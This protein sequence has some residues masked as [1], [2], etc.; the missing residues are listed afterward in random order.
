MPRS[1]IARIRASAAVM[2]LCARMVSTSCSSIVSTGFRLVIGSW[3]IMAISL[4]RRPR[5]STSG[6]FV[7]ST[8]SN[9]T[10]PP[11][12]RP[13][14]CGSRRMIAR[15]VTLLP[16][17]DSPTR[18]RVSP[19]SRSNE[20]PFTAWTVPSWVRNRTVRSR[21]ESSIV[22]YR[23]RRGSI[24]SRSPSPRRVNPIARI[25]IATPG[26]R[27][28]YGAFWRNRAESVSISPHSATRG[29]PGPSPRNPRPATSMIA[30]AIASVAWTISG[31]RAFGIRC[32]NRIRAGVAPSARAAVTK[33]ASRNARRLPR[34]SRAKIGAYETPTASMICTWPWPSQATIPIASRIPGTASRTSVMRIRTVSTLPPTPPASAPMVVPKMSPKATATTPTVRLIRAPYRTRLN[35]SRPSRSVPM[36]WARSGPCLLR[37]RFPTAGSYG[38]MIGASTA[39]STKMAMKTSPRI[40]GPFR[41]NRWNASRHSPLLARGAARTT[42]DVVP[43]AISGIPDPRIEEGIAAVLDPVHHG[44][45]RWEDEGQRLNHDVVVVLDRGHHPR[46]DA[47]PVE[48]G[49]GQDRAATERAHLQSDDGDHRQPGVAHDMA[50]VDPA[51]GEALGPRRP[52]VVL[53]ADVD[54]RGAGD[55]GHDG[56]RDRAEGDRW[57]DQVGEGVDDCI[58]VPREDGVDDREMS[59]RLHVETWIDRAEGRQPV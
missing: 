10:W 56:Q 30:V 55:A 24:A 43:E 3:K 26:K 53:V 42:A 50:V 32:R 25:T 21:T 22:A 8:S 44:V 39:P 18:P 41:N 20:T 23:F 2:R 13:A 28:R 45:N 1:S 47:G 14:G 49:L 15:L 33:S 7:R 6:S 27:I 17:P 58:H 40:A 11:S 54:H 52:H 46:A 4:P 51:P 36:R 34:R 59:H 16:Q 48:D 38:A 57:Q 35:S 9:R 31:V 29:S 5:M 19:S 12:M 37:A